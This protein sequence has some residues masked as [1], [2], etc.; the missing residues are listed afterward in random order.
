MNVGEKYKLDKESIFY[1]RNLYLLEEYS[2]SLFEVLKIE[3]T[4]DGKYKNCFLF[5]KE[6]I[7]AFEENFTYEN[8]CSLFYRVEIKQKYKQDDFDL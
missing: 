1:S 5:S 8:F 4:E 3:R 7:F 6:H 2:D